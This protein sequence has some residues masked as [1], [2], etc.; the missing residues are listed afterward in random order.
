MSHWKAVLEVPILDVEYEQVIAD[1]EGQ[2]R[3]MLDFLGLPWDPECLKFHENRRYVPTASSAQVRR[4][5][6]QNSIG[7][8]RN[9]EKHLSPLL[10]ALART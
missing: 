5:I 8:W 2:T 9:Y 1:A 10:E 7:R 6:Y 3:R 4:P